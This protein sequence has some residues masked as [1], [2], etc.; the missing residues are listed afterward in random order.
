MGRRSDRRALAQFFGD[1]GRAAR[2]HSAV[3][4]AVERVGSFRLRVS[5]SQVAFQRRISFAWTWQAQQY[6]GPRG[7]P[8]VLSVSLKRRDRSRRWKEVVEPS[9]GR[10][11]HHLELYR[12]ADVDAQVRRWLAEAWEAAG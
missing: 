4:R 12:I 3:E 9:K 8:L 6:L 11:V 10:F 7:A 2:L 5:R 1:A